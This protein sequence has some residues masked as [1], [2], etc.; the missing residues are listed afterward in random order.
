VLEPLPAK[1]L[2]DYFRFAAGS[3]KA[4]LL[5][6]KTGEAWTPLSATDFGERTQGLALGL[7]LLGVDRDDRVA[8]LSENRPE[9]PMADFAT[10]SLGALS[11]PI[12]TSYLAPQVEY[13]LRD[14]LAK[15]VVVSSAVEL[16]KV[17]DVRDR[18]PELKHVLVLD[19]VP[20]SAGK[21]TPFATVV[22]KGL[23]ALR[24]DPGAFEERASSILPGDLAT[25][26]YTS[27]TTGEPKGAVLTHEN[28][29]SNVAACSALFDV[30]SDTSAL[31]FLPLAHVFERI[32]DYLFFSRA[33]T[34]TYAES[35][36]NLS[37]NF[38]EVKPHC[39]AAVP[40]VYEKMLMRVQTA[41]EKAPALRRAIFS[42]GVKTGV[43]RLAVVGAGKAPGLFLRL[44]V[45]LADRLVFGKIKARLGGRF[46]FAISGGA[47]LSR[48]VAE[49]FWAAG[50]EVY[51]G[52]GL[53][54]T[55]PVLSCNR[56][57][58]WRLGTVGRA[59][60]GVTL[61]LASDGEVLAKGP[62]VMEGGY[63]RKPDET[64]SVFDAE[65]WFL[66]GDI[67]S[68]DADG[69]LTLTDRKKEIL[70]NAYGKNIAPA[71]IEAALRSVRYVSSAVLIGDRRKFLSALIVPN[72]EKLEAWAL[73]SGV[74]FRDHDALV[75]D[76]KVLSLV[77][78]AI[79]ILNGDEPHE[80]QIRAFTLLTDDFTIDGGELT[81]TMKIKRRV[82]A[83]KYRD[84]IDRMYGEAEEGTASGERPGDS[85]RG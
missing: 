40:R 20:W 23:A 82:V 52:Y 32:V 59:I 83:E 79:D 25:M 12:Y 8:I 2:L 42:W 56:P 71:P 76:P 24:A 75:K 46:R 11:V 39:F 77:K 84:V 62:N 66:T 49:F 5:V 34:I 10:L 7:A 60:P 64:A 3:G 9:W 41:V 14:S 36:E 47:P 58:E 73:S 29:V 13:I 17:V 70:I 85:L 68:F 61:R 35:I 50:I 53:T 72:F 81:P 27:G 54:E 16:Q 30:T 45:A 4:E 15:V 69:F 78:Q 38:I 65:G 33:A 18:C 26:I 63:W 55:S 48:D 31:S 37:E 21:A 6:S 51:E 80:R 74:K 22:Q 28:L 43:R 44:K 57:G 67:G 1:T 19:Q